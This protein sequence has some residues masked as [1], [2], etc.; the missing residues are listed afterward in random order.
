[1]RMQKR[2]VAL[3][4]AVVVAGATDAA[5]EWGLSSTQGFGLKGGLTSTRWQVQG[6]STSNRTGGVAG[7]FARLPVGS[8]ALQAEV[9]WSR[10]GFEK[11]TY[12]DYSN[13]EVNTNN[14][15]IPVCLVIELPASEVHVYL[16]GGV[17]FAFISGTKIRHAD[18]ADWQSADNVLG[19]TNTL[20]VFGLG[21]RHDRLGIEFRLNHGVKNIAASDVAGEIKDRGFA[22]TISYALWD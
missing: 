15:E 9:L 16:L 17:S 22:V 18:A 7:L 21:L 6:G 2:F 20:A 5:A 13:I 12:G 14:W 19:D 3:V 8:V 4:L 11:R 10:K 1:M